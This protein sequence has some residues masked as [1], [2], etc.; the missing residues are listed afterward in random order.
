MLRVIESN[1]RDFGYVRKVADDVLLKYH[2]FICIC[3]MPVLYLH[4]CIVLSCVTFD[5]VV[6]YSVVLYCTVLYCI[7]LSCLVLSSVVLYCVVSS[8]CV[9]LYCMVLCCVVC[10]LLQ[11]QSRTVVRKRGYD[12][13]KL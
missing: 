5:C 8:Y 4:F 1:V 3:N 10:V 2:T 9:V 7:V 12:S 11:M 13:R 6:L